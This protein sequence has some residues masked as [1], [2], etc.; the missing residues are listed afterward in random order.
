MTKILCMKLSKK[1]KKPKK[2]NLIAKW[3]WCVALIPA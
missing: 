1:K 2:T 3:S